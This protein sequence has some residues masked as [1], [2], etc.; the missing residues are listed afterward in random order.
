MVRVPIKVRVPRVGHAVRRGESRA[1]GVEASR[2][3]L[4][5]GGAVRRE[6][7]VTRQRVARM[8]P[9]RRPKK[10][11]AARATIQSLRG[12]NTMRVACTPSPVDITYS[13]APLAPL[14]R[15]HLL[16]LANKVPQVV[17]VHGHNE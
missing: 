8:R 17:L 9:V 15:P 3:P 12:Q 10:R 11:R 4:A 2:G 6:D 1:R 13:S 7:V 16:K 5:A 14:S